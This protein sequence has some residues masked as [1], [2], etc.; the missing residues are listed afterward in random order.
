MTGCSDVA[1]V[2]TDATGRPR[3][4]IKRVMDEARNVQFDIHVPIGSDTRGF[5]H[6]F[7]VIPRGLAPRQKKTAPSAIPKTIR[8]ADA[9]L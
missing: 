6:V 2:E 1:E 4:V 3:L 5:V 7:D 8:Y 9:E